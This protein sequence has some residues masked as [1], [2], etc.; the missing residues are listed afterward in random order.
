MEYQNLDE[1]KI[2]KYLGDKLSPVSIYLFGSYA[3]GNI[4]PESDVD[5][6]FLADGEKDEYQIFNVAQG[7]AGRLIT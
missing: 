6:A 7:L 1:Q 3:K 4:R 2:I 5:I